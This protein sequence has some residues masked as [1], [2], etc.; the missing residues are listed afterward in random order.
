MW[1]AL[2]ANPPNILNSQIPHTSIPIQDEFGRVT[3]PWRYFFISLSARTGSGTPITPQVLQQQI[4]L[5]QQQDAVF[6]QQIGA[7]FVETAMETGETGNLAP[8]PFLAALMVMD[9]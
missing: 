8:D 6:L 2:M 4:T 5:I 3:L 1:G 7:L 9:A